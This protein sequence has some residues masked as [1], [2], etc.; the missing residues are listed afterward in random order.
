MS[1]QDPAPEPEDDEAAGM[2]LETAD[3]ADAR[4]REYIAGSLQMRE[5]ARL[6]A[7]GMEPDEAVKQVK[8]GSD[9]S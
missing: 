6:I 7:D 2:M 3:D 5:I 8:K 1:K 9:D 4:F